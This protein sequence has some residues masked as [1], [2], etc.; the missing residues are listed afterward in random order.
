MLFGCFYILGTL[1]ICCW[2]VCV[3]VCVAAAILHLLE[4]C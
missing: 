1:C 3:W 4:S 2:Y